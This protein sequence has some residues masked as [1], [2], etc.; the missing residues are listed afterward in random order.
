MSDPDGGSPSA[1]PGSA[2]RGRETPAA[3]SSRELMRLLEDAGVLERDEARPLIERYPDEF[4]GDVLV[5]EGML[6]ED[7]LRGLLVR[8]LHI[9]WLAA[10]GCS[11]APDVAALLPETACR[12]RRVM[13]LS[14][15]KGFVT[16]A[17]TN[18]LDP[19]LAEW[20]H[21]ET[22]LEARLVLCSVAGLD[23]LLDAAFHPERSGRQKDDNSSVAASADGGDL[24]G[25]IEA[26]VEGLRRADETAAPDSS[27]EEQ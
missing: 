11:V 3:A 16:L 10:Q 8:A 21:E 23:A 20:V 6:T 4:L 2:P 22:G 5:R 18:P 15:A 12:E 17:T 1:A 9:P 25:S 7:Y 24:A 27:G 14:R 19:H 13:P 26:V